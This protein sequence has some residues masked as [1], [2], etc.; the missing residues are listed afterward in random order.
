MTAAGT[1][2]AMEIPPNYAGTDGF[3]NP[4][5]VRVTDLRTTG[6]Q[7]TE[8]SVKEFGAI[9]DG[10]TDDTNALQTALNYAQAHGVALTIPQG[11]CKTRTLAWHGESIGGLGKQVS[12]LLGFPGQ[13]V[14]ASPTDSPNLLRYTRLHDLTIYVD[15][16]EDVSCSPAEGRAAAGICAISRPL[17]NNSIFSRG[18]NGLNGTTGTGAGWAVGN[19]AIAMPAVS[20][21]GGNGLRVAEIENLEIATVGVDPLAAQYPGI[22]STHTCGHVSGA[23]AAVER[24]PKHRYARD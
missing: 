3:T 12:A 10:V 14:L 4:N 22:H 5:G 2:G 18:G 15:Q 23:M 8:R 9:C 1:S 17:E 7:Q 20:G 11:T 24:V 21:T 13:D 19:C 6:A 16:S